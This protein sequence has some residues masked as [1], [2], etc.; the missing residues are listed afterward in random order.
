MLHNCSKG[1]LI[2]IIEQLKVMNKCTLPSLTVPQLEQ[3]CSSYL[4]DEDINVKILST[5]ADDSVPC[6]NIKMFSGGVEYLFSDEWL[7]DEILSAYVVTAGGYT[8]SKKDRSDDPLYIH[9]L[10]RIEELK[11]S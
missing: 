9:F 7:S 10:N 11:E 6:L 2:K 8:Y 3:I 1:E 5:F 4:T